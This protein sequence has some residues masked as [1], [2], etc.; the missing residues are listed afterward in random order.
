MNKLLHAGLFRLKKSR[1]F[2][3]ALSLSFVLGILITSSQANERAKWLAAG[4]EN[5]F[6]MDNVFFDY[7]LVGPLLTA[8]FVPLFFGTEYSDGAIRNK[9]ATG[10]S[11]WA[12]YLSNLTL[13]AGVA[14]LF[15]A[16]YMLPVYIL[17]K[18]LLDPMELPASAAFSILAGSILLM[19]AVCGILT[20]VQM[21]CT[22]KAVTTSI[23]L[24]LIFILLAIG[25]IH[26]EKI[27]APEY[28]SGYTTSIN[29]ALEE[30]TQK[31]PHYLEGAK[32]TFYE[33][34]LDLN[35]GGQMLQYSIRHPSHPV[36]MPLLSLGLLALSTGAGLTVFRKKDLK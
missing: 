17:G 11:R 5:V 30:I 1:I 16:A 12:V 15:C 8:V 19:L 24:L 32:R 9:L 22:H 3:V 20:A 36:R 25:V 35:P 2:W 27:I 29:G 10:H 23:S 31:N 6:S 4:Y 14:L 21:L 26:H 18:L 28:T 7:V 33:W 13:S 34:M